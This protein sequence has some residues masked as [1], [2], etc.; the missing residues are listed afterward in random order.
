MS[1]PN[2]SASKS[3]VHIRIDSDDDAARIAA[4]LEALGYEV[5][6]ELDE[7]QGRGRL[8]WAIDQL[9]RRYGLTER[10]REVLAGVL[11]GRSNAV[12]ASGLEISQA[13]AKWHL[14][15]VFGKTKTNNR[16][17]LLRLALQLGSPRSDS[18]SEP[19]QAAP[20]PEE[21]ANDWAEHDEVTRRIEP[22]RD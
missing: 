2:Q 11:E 22:S 3:E 5:V 16:E 6:R 4:V 15:N 14:H 8:D 1:K 17:S 10:E 20:E 19:E 7:G 12:V 18:A 13:T 21:A 9:G